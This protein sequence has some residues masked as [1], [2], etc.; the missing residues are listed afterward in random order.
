MT[1]S[2]EVVNGWGQVGVETTGQGQQEKDKPSFLKIPFGDTKV[3]ILDAFP[4]VYKEWWAPSGNGA[5]R[6]DA[7]NS[8]GCSIAY[9]PSGDL[10]EAE[11]R[12]FMKNVFAQADAQGLKDKARKDFLRDFGY[13]QQPWGKLKDKNIIHVLD[14]ATGEV[15]LL[16]SGN[17]IFNAIKAFAMN[18]EYGDPRNYDITIN[19]TDTKGKGFFADIKY[20]VT[21]ARENVPLTQAEIDLYN[22]KKIDLKEYKAPNYTPEQALLIA[23]GATFKEILGEDGDSPAQ[24]DSKSDA[25]Q[26]PPTQPATPP[27]QET[28]PEPEQKVDINKEDALTEDEL[29]DISFG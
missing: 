3:R 25:G 14:R 12:A 27:A 11:N 8:N 4:H 13:K 23:K 16:D 9:F 20:T 6:P 10:L 5:N 29:K 17:G 19:K 7:E 21:P 1:N 15:K 18:P 26:L 24:V 22:A 2:N 28:Q